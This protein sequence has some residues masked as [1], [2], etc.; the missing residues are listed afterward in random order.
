MSEVQVAVENALKVAK[1]DLKIAQNQ[2]SR[3]EEGYRESSKAT[4][5]LLSLDDR[6]P[7]GDLLK[8][9]SE[10]QKTHKDAILKQYPDTICVE[11]TEY[12]SDEAMG[13]FRIAL[14]NKITRLQLKI[15]ELESF[16]D[17]EIQ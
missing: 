5:N 3:Y 4:V 14:S 2:L 17:G 11:W 1:S 6:L 12:S 7:L 8:R 13:R 16:L 10:I 9:L 15:I